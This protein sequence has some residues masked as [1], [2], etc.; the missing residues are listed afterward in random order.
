MAFLWL[1]RRCS[2]S[3][4]LLILLITTH[5]AALSTTGCASRVATKNI[6][7]SDCKTRL[8]IATMDSEFKNA[9]V[10]EVT[11]TLDGDRVCI[12][13]IDVEDL[14]ATATRTFAAVVLITDYQF[15]RMDGDARRFVEKADPQQK[16]KLV[17]LTT[18]G[19]PSTVSKV[20]EVDAITA[21][22][23]PA[24]VAALAKRIA[25]KVRAR[26]SLK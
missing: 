11:K 18:A 17:L 12:K 20:P 21:A 23:K 7:T 16:K 4:R 5:L 26:L 3:S 9:V 6:A 10:S 22:S 14:A 1:E 8:L 13:I 24:D 19:T 15:F 25:D 2:V